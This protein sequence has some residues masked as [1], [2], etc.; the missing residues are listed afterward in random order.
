MVN[1]TINA[2][3]QL[4]ATQLEPENVKPTIVLMDLL[5]IPVITLVLLVQLQQ[6]QDA[7]L[8]Q[9]FQE[10]LLALDV[11]LVTLKTVVNVFH[12]QS[13]IQLIVLQLLTLML[14]QKHVRWMDK[15]LLLKLALMAMVYTKANAINVQI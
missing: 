13:K 8:A 5:M 1:A 12:A 6:T 3:Q 10:L 4:H 14:M 11:L 7:M 15:K 2:K 9:L